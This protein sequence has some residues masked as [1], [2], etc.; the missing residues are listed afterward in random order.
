MKI[1]TK[2]LLLLTCLAFLVSMLVMPGLAAAQV[3]QPAPKSGS[4]AESSTA[5]STPPPLRGHGPPISANYDEQLGLTF[6]Q[7]FT[8]LSYNVTAVEQTDPTLGTGPAYLLDGLSNTGYW[9]QVGLSWNWSPGTN[10]GTGFDVNYEVFDSSG[11]SIFP[12][13]GDGGILAFSGA[14]APS[15]IVTLSLGF[16]N[17]SQ[18]IMMAE[19]A[20]TGAVAQITYSAEGGTYFI[21]LPN[22]DANSNGFFTG[23][24]TEWYHGAPYYSNM[25]EVVYSSN[26]SLSSAWMWMDEFNANNNQLVFASN[27]TA[28]SMFGTGPA[29]LQEFSYSGITE[30]ADASEFITGAA[31]NSTTT[32]TGTATVTSTETVTTTVPTTITQTTTTTVPTTI[33]QTTTTTVPTTITQ[34]TTTT[35]TQSVTTTATSI[36]STTITDTTTSTVP[37]STTTITQTTTQIQMTPPTQSLPLWAYG[38]MVV[39]LLAGLGAGYLI[40]SPQVSRPKAEET[41]AG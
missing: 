32:T 15:D 8:S 3:P 34:T 21:G 2:R 38:L 20:N 25:Q 31:S 28:L 35:A 40:K 16:T 39:L 5:A 17:S 7:N 19:D 22:S 41:P 36:Q 4:R 18:V 12:T 13:N 27:A 30:F 26:F 33:T 14:V 11:N 10:P 9:Y 24:M 1:L 29:Q 6:T 37:P 23:L